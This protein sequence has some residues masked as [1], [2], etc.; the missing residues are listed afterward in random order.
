M[1]PRMAREERT[2][3]AMVRMYCRAHHA[4]G[5]EL[6]SECRELLEYAHE[7]LLKCPFQEGKTT[8]ALCPV[9]CYRPDMRDKIRTVM[10][11]SGPRMIYRHPVLAA[12]H[13]LDRRRKQPLRK[14]GSGTRSA[15]Q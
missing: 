4:R 2:V 10:R 5:R 13:M 15:V 7:R 14:S 12:Q 3:A 8:C 1:N 11:H 6:C 9:H